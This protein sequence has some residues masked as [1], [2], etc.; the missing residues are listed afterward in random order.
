MQDIYSTIN[1]VP[2]GNPGQ[3]AYVAGN[4]FMDALAGHRLSSGLSATSLQLGAWESKLTEN[5][6]F[7]K[8][9]TYSMGNE[10]GIPLIIKAMTLPVPVQVIAKLDTQQLSSVPAYRLDPYFAKLVIPNLL[11][12]SSPPKPK[13]G[14]LGREEVVTVVDMILRNILEVDLSERLGNPFF[15]P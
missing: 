2:L 3:L 15:Y 4:S 5:P 11:N 12:E 9:I 14:K 1:S 6:N 10:E 13:N 8:G 7:N